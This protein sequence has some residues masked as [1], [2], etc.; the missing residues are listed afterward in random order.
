MTI[1]D[2]NHFTMQIFVSFVLQTNSDLYLMINVHLFIIYN[3]INELL[4][5]QKSCKIRFKFIL[6]IYVS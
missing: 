2:S 6:I 4:F 3:F 5:K 1:L